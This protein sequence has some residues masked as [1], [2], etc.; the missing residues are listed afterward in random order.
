MKKRILIVLTSWNKLGAT[1][2]TT[3]LW[4][5]EFT[6]P[7]YRFLDAGHKITAASPAGGKVPIDP[8]SLKEENQT[9]STRRFTKSGDKVLDQTQPLAYVR[10]EDFDA[11]FYPGGHGPMWDLSRDMENAALISELFDSGKIIGAVCHG[12][13]ALVMAIDKASK[14]ILSGRKVTGFSNAEE[15]FVKLEK[16]V[17]FLLESRM[18]ELGG[19]YSKGENW[20]PHVVTDGKLVTGQNP[21][22]ADGVAEAMLALLNE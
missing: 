14:P 8:E 1:G 7:Y 2:R 6:T 11:V 16:T 4:L 3:G 18:K 17:P 22:S 19:L 10:A 13:A 9:E 5:E 12:P 15:E 20:T 21:Q